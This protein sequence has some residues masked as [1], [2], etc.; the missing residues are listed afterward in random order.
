MNARFL[1]A[2]LLLLAAGLPQVV[3]AGAGAPHATLLFT[4]PAR[5]DTAQVAVARHDGEDLP[6]PGTRSLFDHHVARL[7]AL[8]YPFAA[9]IDSFRPFDRWN[10]G[11]V[12][13][14]VP[15][16]RSLRRA[17]ADFRQPRALVAAQVDA[18]FAP[19][20]IEPFY[21]GRLFLGFVEAAD[22]IEVISY[23]EA[24]GRFEYQLVENYCSGCVPRIVY[25]KRVVCLTCHHAGAPIFSSRPWAE[26]NANIA[27]AR[28][29]AAAREVAWLQAGATRY[30][31][32]T[33]STQLLTP[34]TFDELTVLGAEIPVVQ[35]IW[36]EACGADGLACRRSIL[37]QALGLVMDPGAFHPQSEASERTRALQR[38]HWPRGGVRI[39]ENLLP[40]RDPIADR[41]VIDRLV[42]DIRVRFARWRLQL[43]GE[44]SAS[45]D[46]ARKLSF[47]NQTTHLPPELDPRT[48]R[49]PRATLQADSL[50][51]VHG[52]AR[53]FTPADRRR[54]REWSNDDTARVEQL[55]RSGALDELLGPAPVSRVPVLQKVAQLLGQEVPEYCCLDTGGFSPPRMENTPP[56]AIPAGSVLETFQ[57]YCFA[58]HRGNPVQRLNFMGAATAQA[59]LEE[60]R[61]KPEI[62]DVLDYARYENSEKEGTLMPPRNS[63]QR[64]A[65]DAARRTGGDDIRRMRDAV[66]AM[67]GF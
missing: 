24:A 23:N 7:G 11:S 56:L 66:P 2:C 35:K 64:A 15:D 21:S 59:V 52:V 17:E 28:E 40:S 67:F 4:S 32:V 63:E 6:P 54:L 43:A 26:T 44:T 50:Y 27:V 22:E 12:S 37:A 30:Q 8:P 47:F 39:P 34:E 61:A 49:P 53:L 45:H 42:Q 9:L 41:S 31:G 1:G 58:C 62:R 51:A 14:L 46:S 29:I 38:R 19:F 10:S 65:L 48:L 33:L 13:L 60:I 57:R 20:E 36:I 5:A 18:P 55:V 16:G 3:P 25:A